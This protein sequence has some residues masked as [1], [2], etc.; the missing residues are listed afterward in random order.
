MET[1]LKEIL[2]DDEGRVAA[3]ITS[4]GEKI[5]CQFVGLTAGV[6]PNIDFLRNT[7]L[8]VN[9]GVIVDE[10][11]STNLPDVYAIGDCAEFEKAPA[12]DR[13]TIEQVWYTGRMHGETLAYSLCNKPVPYRPGVWFNSAKFLDIEY[14]TYG[15]VP[16]DWD[17]NQFKN[18]YWEHRGG[19]VAFRMLMD[20]EGKIL[21]VNN[22]GF[23][24]RHEVLDQAIRES[25]SGGKVMARLEHANFDPEF[26]LH[27]I[28][29][30]FRRLSRLNLEAI[31]I[32][33]RNRS[34]KNFRS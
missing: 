27:L 4:K 15:T 32:R 34:S 16:A 9:R 2:S 22:F 25:W 12:A 1:E 29:L 7:D 26:F 31:F 14:Q 21:G 30:R 33:P 20:L 11:F 6:S 8:K 10:Y 28:I 5:N 23:R 18:F 24:L 17:E 19:K 3:V 13:R